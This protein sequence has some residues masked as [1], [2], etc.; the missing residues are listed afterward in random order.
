MGQQHL[1]Y[2]FSQSDRSVVQQLVVARPQQVLIEAAVLLH[3][4]E[5]GRS[6]AE[7]KPPVQHRAVE[8]LAEDV[9]LPA[10]SRLVLRVADLIPELN[11]PPAVQTPKAPE[12]RVRL[13][14]H[15]PPDQVL[16][17]AQR[18]PRVP[19]PA[20]ARPRLVSCLWWLR[21][22][23]D[24]LT[25]SKTIAEKRA[26]IA[27]RK[28]V[29]AKGSPRSWDACGSVGLIYGK[30]AGFNTVVRTCTALPGLPLNTLLNRFLRPA[31][32][33]CG[34]RTAH[35][36]SRNTLCSHGRL[37]QRALD[38]RALAAGV[39]EAGGW[40]RGVASE[41][42][43]EAEHV[44]GAPLDHVGM[45]VERGRCRGLCGERGHVLKVA[46]LHAGLAHSVRAG[47][48]GLG[49]RQLHFLA[50]QIHC[51]PIEESVVKGEHRHRRCR[52]RART[53][54]SAA[55]RGRLERRERNHLPEDEFHHRV[56]VGRE[57]T[58]AA[59]DVA[60]KKRAS[61]HHHVG[62]ESIQTGD[63]KRETLVHLPIR[64]VRSR[65]AR[66][67]RPSFDLAP[68][69]ISDAISGGHV[70]STDANGWRASGGEQR[71]MRRGRTNRK[72]RCERSLG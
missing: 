23:G 46:A 3:R 52:R 11:V 44:L 30:R 40:A 34:H 7:S 62:G 18:C 33:T 22:G 20:A 26:R 49:A 19:L 51:S 21:N 2:A 6:H 39:L 5:R 28:R 47:R 35:R 64:N 4:L 65:E 58:N 1:P 66:R 71:Y 25:R 17:A 54:P 9:R 16:A 32:L 31:S 60:R 36:A 45:K 69:G 67:I 50:G 38:G 56:Y 37:E 14:R 55:T 59:K 53:A 72:C 13:G 8:P 63:A 57:S 15:R 29:L 68:S 12:H 10:P 42:R 61:Q 24:S 43:V 27:D 70:R 41:R 48:A